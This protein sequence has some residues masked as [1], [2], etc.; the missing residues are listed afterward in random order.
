MCIALVEDPSLGS[1]ISTRRLTTACDFSSRVSDALSSICGYCV[2][3]L[4]YVRTHIKV[5]V[6]GRPGGLCLLSQHL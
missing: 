6:R 1:S 5:H 2:H 3:V 4:I